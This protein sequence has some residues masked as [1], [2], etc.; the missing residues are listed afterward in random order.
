MNI[1]DI[2]LSVCLALCL[3]AGGCQNGRHSLEE[4]DFIYY[5]SMDG[6]SLVKEEYETGAATTD[7]AID[8][9]LE[10]LDENT[11]SIDY[12]SVFPSDVHVEE[13]ERKDDKLDLY[14]NQAYEAM[15]SSEEVLLRAAVVQC[16]GQLPEVSCVMFYVDHEPLKDS[17]G[18][19]VGYMHPEDFIQNTG[20]AIHAYQKGKLKLYFANKKGN[21]L[22]EKEVSVRYNRNTSVE[23][24]IVEQLIKG[25]SETDVYPVIPPETNVIG[26]SIKDG[27]CYVNLDENFLNN[28]YGA[29]PTMIIYS[30]VNSIVEGGN[31][32]R[33][34]ISVNGEND[35]SYMGQVDLSKPLSRDLDLVEGTES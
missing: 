32:S 16:L 10:A 28:T 14:F 8:Q 7:Q 22:V 33:V 9:M 5:V 31:A 26:V 2:M 3:L 19:P 17:D 1:R 29:D 27:V 12:K 11:E 18:N 15:S 30:I 23:K 24:V 4:K 35:I 25:P 20:S 21:K 13:W 6:S 34:Q